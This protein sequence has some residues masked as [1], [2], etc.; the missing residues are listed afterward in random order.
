MNKNSTQGSIRSFVTKTADSF[1]IVPALPANLQQ[2]YLCILVQCFTL[3]TYKPII[4]DIKYFIVQICSSKIPLTY[5]LNQGQ[6]QLK[7]QTVTVN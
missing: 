6:P 4:R 1:K 3:G 5:F 7:L 2:A